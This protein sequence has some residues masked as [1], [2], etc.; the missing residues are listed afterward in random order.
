MDK[1]LKLEI[2]INTTSN[3][4][5]MRIG[6][7]IHQQLKGNPDYI[8]NRIVLNIDRENRVWLGIFQDC[9]TVPSIVIH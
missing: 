8:E 6:T 9:E 1:N 7:E 5:K 2:L 3:E 4:E